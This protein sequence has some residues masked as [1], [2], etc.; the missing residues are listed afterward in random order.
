VGAAKH[1]SR[2]DRA[3]MGFRTKRLRRPPHYFALA[4]TRSSTFG[5]YCPDRRAASCPASRSEHGLVMRRKFPRRRSWSF[6]SSRSR[7]V[8]RLESVP[9]AARPARTSDPRGASDSAAAT[10]TRGLRGSTSLRASA[11]SACS[12]WTDA[13]ARQPMARPGHRP[14]PPS[15]AL[16][17]RS[18]GGHRP[19]PALRGRG[20][21]RWGHQKKVGA[22][23]PTGREH[24]WTRA[25]QRLQ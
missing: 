18:G 7:G 8:A 14:P 15:P 24:G 10:A 9:D 23:R 20:R 16:R 5:N 4:P 17:G 19:Q 11:S 21:M 22:R 2:R 13:M 3:P 25:W 1:E 12:T 6:A